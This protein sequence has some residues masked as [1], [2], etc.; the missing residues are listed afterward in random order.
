MEN[1]Y[2]VIVIGAGNGGLMAAAT[3]AK[4]GLKTIIFERNQVPGGSATSFRRGRFEFEAS[5]HEMCNIGTKEN[6]GSVRKLFNSIGLDLDFCIENTLFRAIAKGDDGYD[7]TLPSGV[8]EFCRTIEKEV[9][10]SYDSV[11]AVFELAEKSNKAIAYLSSGKPD[12]NVLISEHSDFLRM[13]SHS[14][15]E[16]LNALN[17]PKK[18]QS[19][20]LTYW[21]YLGASADELD[22]SYYAIVLERYVTRF[23]AIPHLRSHEISLAIE[24][25][26]R[27]NKGEI[28]YGT[29][30][31]KILVKD[32][33]AYGV[34]VNGKEIHSKYVIAN[35]YPEN[36]YGKMIDIENVPKNA[37]KLHN[38]R[39]H[40]I[41]FFNVYLGLNR[42]HSELNINDYSVFIFNS[43]DIDEQYESIKDIEKSM[44]IGNCL[45]VAV[46][47]ASPDG[48]C[49]VS[50]TTIFTDDAWGIVSDEEYNN[51]K[52]HVAE[53]LIKQYEDTLNVSIRPYIEEI[54]IAAPPTFARYL[55]T[56]NGT[57]Y[58]YH[59]KDY[60]SMLLRTMNVK[61]ESFIKNLHFTG[62]FAERAGGY[63]STY[64]NGQNVASRIIKEEKANVM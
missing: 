24:K 19:I 50:L 38:A 5:L 41:T 7:I 15:K 43:S 52:E 12:M 59:I 54:V 36:V 28:I 44:M 48:T 9:P 2:D 62:A 29:E 51:L 26:I 35:C 14:V 45:N 4:A 53:R 46:N 20:L 61:K 8:E 55:N 25:I 40:G 64:A 18:A 21:S 57:P 49:I 63:S 11:K 10:G 56:P 60:D 30:V 22:F 34:V 37:V 23:P 17:M 42:S 47:D 1:N 13:A 27:D 31:E 33:K 39:E 32:N 58:G 16:G 3:C 6:P